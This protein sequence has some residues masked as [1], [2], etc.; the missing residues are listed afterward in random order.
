MAD[1]VEESDLNQMLAPPVELIVEDNDHSVEIG[2]A[3]IKHEAGAVTE[4]ETESETECDRI[5]SN[6]VRWS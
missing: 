2:V 6:R 1:P 4:P 3:G 5:F